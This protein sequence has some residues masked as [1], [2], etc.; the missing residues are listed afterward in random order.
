[1][2]NANKAEFYLENGNHIV[3]WHTA[4]TMNLI[5]EYEADVKN[6]R[7]FFIGNWEGQIE[8]LWYNGRKLDATN[9]SLP[10][11]KVDLHKFEG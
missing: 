5:E 1:M 9:F 4:D 2:S 7:H 6:G 3:F 10:T 8:E 11:T